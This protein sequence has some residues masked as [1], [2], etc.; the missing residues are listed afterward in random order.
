MALSAK[1]GI[2]KI[3]VLLFGAGAERS[4][5]APSASLRWSL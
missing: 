5:S 4:K 1:D 3:E 2:R